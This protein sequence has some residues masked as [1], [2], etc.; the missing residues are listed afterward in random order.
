MSIATTIFHIANTDSQAIENA[1][2]AIFADEDRPQVLRLE[3]TYSAVLER[4]TDPDLTAAYR[5]L[6]L[7]PK[8]T[9]RWTTLL[10]L[11]NRTEGLETE[12]SKRLNG[13]PVF[14]LYTYGEDISGYRLA[15]GDQEVDQYLSDPEYAESL[16][17]SD[18][19]A[20]PLTLATAGQADT[21]RGHPERFAELFPAGTTPEEFARVVLAPGYWETHGAVGTTGPSTDGTTGVNQGAE[22]SGEEED[23]VDEVD[24]LR[25]IGLGLEFW[26][27]E[28]YPFAEE[29]EDIP[30]AEAGP[31][32][33]LAF[34]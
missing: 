23:V 10:E 27:P 17:T 13:A 25:C 7:R 32:I 4:V 12:L 28:S 8:D 14:A 2:T 9:S 1:L 30:N 22:E 29:L 33:V 6:I 34:A 18:E 24:R 21:L 16:R 19:E 3:G 20:V 26:R 31:A 15:R 5:Y 11:G